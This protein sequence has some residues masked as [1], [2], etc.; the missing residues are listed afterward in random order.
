MRSPR[1]ATPRP[2]TGWKIA[3][4]QAAFGAQ[5][6]QQHQLLVLA[7]ADHD[8]LR[9]VQERLD[10][11]RGGSGPFRAHLKTPSRGDHQAAWAAR[12]VSQ[13]AD[14]FLMPAAFFPPEGSVQEGH[15]VPI[16]RPLSSS[17]KCWPRG[18]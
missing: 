15:L 14:H 4:P 13:Q 10:Q 12:N 17:P 16:V 11:F 7:P 3:E 6:C 2:R 8:A 9:P 5:Q 18:S 1:A